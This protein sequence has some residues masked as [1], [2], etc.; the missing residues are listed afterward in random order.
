MAKFKENNFILERYF[1]SRSD[2]HFLNGIVTVYHCHHYATLYTQ[3]ALDSG[4][5]GLLKGVAEET[6]YKILKDYYEKYNIV[7][8]F[9]KFEL[10]RQYFAAVGLGKM[11]PVFAGEFSGLVKL[12][13]SHIDQ[14]WIKKWGKYDKPVNYIGAGFI[15]AMFATAF[16]TPPKSFNVYE[17]ESIVMGA[18]QS[19]FNVVKQ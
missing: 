1:D 12:I 6:F 8:M 3:L 18:E 7:K 11:D 2:R 14:G 10:A 9:E 16:N 15:G 4:E 13:T 17:W 5:T 19:I